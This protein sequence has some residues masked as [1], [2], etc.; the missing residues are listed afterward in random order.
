MH[1]DEAAS[2]QERVKMDHEMKQLHNIPSY[3][4]VEHDTICD[5]LRQ[6]VA[7]G[8]GPTCSRQPYH[9]ML[10]LRV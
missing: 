1:D 5:V 4:T 9:D 6:E 2:T 8:Q 10:L 3:A 7:R